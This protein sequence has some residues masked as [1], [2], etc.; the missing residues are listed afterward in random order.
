ME[1]DNLTVSLEPLDALRFFR[2]DARV[3]PTNSFALK[4]IGEGDYRAEFNGLSKDCYIKEMR[5]GQTSA[6]EDGFTV[7]RGTPAK[8]EVTIS[9][10]GA[11]VEGN[12]ADVDGLPA[13]GVWV[14]LIPDETLRS[15]SRLY[16]AGTTDQYG[17]FELR[18]IAP[19][20]YKLFSWQEAEDG[21]WEDPEFLKLFEGKGESVSLREGDQK[22][23]HLRA[24][25]PEKRETAIL[26]QCDRTTG[27]AYS[28]HDRSQ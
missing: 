17:R 1:K 6:L 22:T 16:K 15:Q 28:L 27:V 24:I 10:R 25:R 13:T 20:D 18:G 8:L 3:G 5:Y 11:R 23:V 7:T 21:A 4:D 9:S 12:V 2:G 26:G 19:G 14:V